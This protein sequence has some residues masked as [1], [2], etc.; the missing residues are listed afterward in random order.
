VARSEGASE[1][2]TDQAERHTITLKE[3]LSRASLLVEH[4]YVTASI[5]CLVA[6][7]DPNSIAKASLSDRSRTPEES[8][9]DSRQARGTVGSI[10]FVGFQQSSTPKAVF[11]FSALT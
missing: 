6:G 5:V 7:G 10:L 1:L 9:N 8:S 2:A 11:R 4:L 3:G